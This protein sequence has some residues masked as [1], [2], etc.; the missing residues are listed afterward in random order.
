MSLETLTKPINKQKNSTK[1]TTKTYTVGSL[2]AGIGGICQGFI[3][4]GFKIQWANEIDKQ[5]CITYRANFKHDLIE[6]DITKLDPKETSKV[7]I[8][9]GGFPCQAFSVAGYRKGFTD[10]R[11]TLFFDI[12]RF[13][14]FHKP[15]VIFLENVKN[16]VGHDKGNTLKTILH[17]LEE[18]RGYHCKHIVMNTAEYGN[19][20]QNRE[21]FYL[22]AF[23]DKKLCDEFEFPKPIELTTKIKDYI[24]LCEDKRFFYTNNKIYALLQEQMTNPNTLYQWRRIYVRENKSNLCP[25]LTANMGTGGHNVPLIL[26][27]NGIRKLTPRECASLQGFKNKFILPDTLPNSALYKQIGNSVSIPVIERIAKNIYN[28][29]NRV[30]K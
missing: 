3:N 4:S 8:L 28:V 18:V 22:V 9:A 30:D 10:T 14:D 29:L 23:N 6:A 24:S 27:E 2:F 25:T 12:L 21:R 19:I 15:T 26:A 1:K 5:A 13:I 17:E 11:G 20:P 16:I 7:D